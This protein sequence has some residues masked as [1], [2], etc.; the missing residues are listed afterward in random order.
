[1]INP[2][3]AAR[4]QL[5]LRVVLGAVVVMLFSAP[6]VVDAQGLV[7]GVRQGAQAGNRAAGPVGGVLGGAIGGVVGVFSGVLGAGK[8]GPAPAATEAN[9]PKQT[10]TAKTAKT[11]KGAKAS[12]QAVLTQEGEPRMTAQQNVAKSA[13]HRGD[14][15]FEPRARA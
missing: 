13:V 9:P 1:M 12:K 3:P 7:Q 2:R 10:D 5:K 15:A 14:G 8:S 4:A 11:G 6:S